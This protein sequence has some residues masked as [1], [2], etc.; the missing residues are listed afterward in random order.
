MRR[1]PSQAPRRRRRRG[2]PYVLLA[3]TLAIELAVPTGDILSLSPG[4]RA[5]LG[6]LLVFAP[7][8]AGGTVFSLA[9]RPSRLTRAFATAPTIAVLRALGWPRSVPAALRVLGVATVGLP[10]AA[11]Q[12]LASARSGRLSF[13][14]EC[15]AQPGRSP[16]F[17]SSRGCARSST[18]R[19]GSASSGS[20]SGRLPR[21]RRRWSRASSE[22]WG[23]AVSCSAT[24]PTRAH[25]RSPS[26]R[27]LKGRSPSPP[28]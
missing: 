8:L 2:A 13:S 16:P 14:G 5:V 28:R 11:S 23:P 15:P 9:P 7:L 20:C 27:R 25:A 26:T 3:C 6:S 19:C 18:R 10:S 1:S 17:S 21:P 12:N 22:A 24:G 4:A